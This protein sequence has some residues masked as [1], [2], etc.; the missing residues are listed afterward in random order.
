MLN[1]TKRDKI[2]NEVIRSE[3]GMIDVLK[4]VQCMKG[5]WA[6]HVARIS[7]TRRARIT[8][9]WTAI[10]G[11][12]VRG[13]LKRRCRYSNEEVGSSQWMGV[14]QNRSAWSELRKLSA[15]SGMNG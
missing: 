3:A 14:A 7:N 13:R 12:Q 1:I 15:S 8:S 9:E 4:R 10:D 11:T 2:R 6:G 5:Q